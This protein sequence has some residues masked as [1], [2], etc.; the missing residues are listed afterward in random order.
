V[1]VQTLPPTHAVVTTPFQAEIL[2]MGLSKVTTI[3]QP[4]AVVAFGALKMKVPSCIGLTKN[5][6]IF[7]CEK[8]ANE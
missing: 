5:T 8:P 4:D 7:K 6:K 1:K 2:L 3:V